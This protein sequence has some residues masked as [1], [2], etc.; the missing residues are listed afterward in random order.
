MHYE[1]NEDAEIKYDELQNMALKFRPKMLIAG[2]SSYPRHY[3]YQKMKKIADSVGAYLL[4][5]MAHISGLVAAGVAP[6]PFDFS[7]IVT[8]TTHKTLQGARGAMIFYRKG[9]RSTKKNGEPI[10]YNL[11]Q[12][13]NESVFPGH[14]GGPHL[15]NIAATAIA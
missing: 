8:T 15:N 4:S 1:Y 7:D 9:Q 10:M 12:K 6:S 13:I 3:D 2:Y 5:D 11:E 14:Q